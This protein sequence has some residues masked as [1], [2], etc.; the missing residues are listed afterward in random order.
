MDGKKVIA[1]IPTEIGDCAFGALLEDGSIIGYEAVVGVNGNYFITEAFEVLDA[2]K[3]ED[4]PPAPADPVTAPEAPS[5]DPA[6]Q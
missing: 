1:L 2:L 5:A 4:V 6:G 3:P